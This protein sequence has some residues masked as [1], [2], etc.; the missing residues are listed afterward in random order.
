MKRALS[1]RLH[2]VLS[3]VAKRVKGPNYEVDP[4]LPA[5]AI[6][7]IG[8]RR[9]IAAAR[10]LLRGVAHS[11]GPSG[12]VFLG[13]DVELRNRYLITF[14]RGVTIGRG[15]VIDGLSRSGVTLGD[16][17]T[18]AQ[19]CIIE[20]SGV[21]T[22]LGTGCVIGD[23]SALG[24]YSFVGAAGGVTIGAD[25]IMGNRVSFHSENHRFGNLDTPI[26]TQGVSRVG[27]VI[28]DN[29][30]VGANVA[31]LDGAH[32]ET[33]SVIAAGSVVRGRIPAY[34]VAAGVPAVVLRSRHST[35]PSDTGF[36]HPDA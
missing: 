3:A 28:E 32:V 16:G 21:I 34:S 22:N 12:W 23:R 8:S 27:I 13:R 25:V 10:G 20:A 11:I 29:C 9:S 2:D 24:C 18:L 33:G 31:F 5:R 35:R 19:Y 17:V 6:V 30:W 4:D 1:M 26:R 7:S 36:D 15:C 14:G